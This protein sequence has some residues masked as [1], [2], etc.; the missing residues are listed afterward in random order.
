[1]GSYDVE[2]QNIKNQIKEK[3]NPVN[4]ILFGSCAKGVVRRGSDVDLCVIAET[5]NKRKL[6]Q[7]IIFEVEYNI[8]LDVVVYTPSE[9]KKYKNNKAMFAHII[10]K[11]GVSL[12]GGL[13]NL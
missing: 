11:T 9:W 3:F 7:D 5:D 4:I 13:K 2:I 8:D 1:M 10:Y 6:V 12:F